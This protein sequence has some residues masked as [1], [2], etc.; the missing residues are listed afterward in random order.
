MN[1]DSKTKY[2]FFSSAAFRIAHKAVKIVFDHEDKLVLSPYDT[3]ATWEAIKKHFNIETRYDLLDHC[4][5]KFDKAFFASLCEKLSHLASAGDKLCLHLF[6]DAGIFLAK[7]TAALLPNVSEKLLIKNNLNIVCVGSVWKSWDLLQN[8]FKSEIAKTT[9]KFGLNLI[10]LTQAMAIGAAYIAADHINY[11]LPRDY[12]HNYNIFQYVPPNDGIK[13]NGTH[14]N[15]T[16]T[17]GNG[18]ATNGTLTNGKHTNGTS[19]GTTNGTTNGKSNGTTNG[20]A[21]NGSTANGVSNGTTNGA[22]PN[23]KYTSGVQVKKGPKTRANASPS[24]ILVQDGQKPLEE[25]RDYKKLNHF[26]NL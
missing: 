7:A 9:N 8:G 18:V 17:N 23:G 19:N 13:T 15:G 3:S 25:E 16:Y 2:L 24:T 1:Q 10:T 14:T 5:A 4:Y 20:T 21:T 26:N 12:S 11:D 6:E 22:T